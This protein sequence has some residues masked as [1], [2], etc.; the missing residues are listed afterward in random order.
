MINYFICDDCILFLR[1]I[2]DIIENF[3]MNN[4]LDFKVYLYNSIDRIFKEDIKKIKGFNIYIL[5]IEVGDESGIDLSRYIREELDD[6]NSFIILLTVHNELKYEVL[7]KR[8]FIFDFINKYDSYKKTLVEDLSKI[9]K[10]YENS[11]RRFCYKY[12]RTLKFVSFTNI[13]LFEKIKN[14][15][16]TYL[17]TDDTKIEINEGINSIISKLDNRFMKVDRS[18]IINRNKISN[19]DIDNNC[20]EMSNGL[21]IYD[22][23]KK[24]KKG[25]NK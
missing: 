17:I 21:K 24:I 7:G 2:K 18:M 9:I 4:D 16:S 3:M 6:W 20:F 15:N 10:N 13:I 11:N 22:L 14:S 1:G 5:D 8:L 25:L 23:S 12:N 19:Y